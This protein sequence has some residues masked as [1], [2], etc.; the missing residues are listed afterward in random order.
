MEMILKNKLPAFL[1]GILFLSG[2]L[3]AASD[4]EDNSVMQ[5]YLRNVDSVFSVDYI[6]STE[7]DFSCNVM[8]IF[9]ITDQR[10]KLKDIDTASYRLFFKDGELDSTYIIDTAAIKKNV[11]PNSFH[12]SVPWRGNNTFHFY[13]NDTGAGRLAIGF[14]PAKIDGGQLLI[15]LFNINRNDYM[16]EQVLS[17]Y[18]APEAL[19][20][21]SESFLFQRHDQFILLKRF[22]KHA[23]ESGLLSRRYSRQIIEFYDYRIN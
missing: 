22:E 20:R 3:M 1:P 9:R 13:P 2:L 17:H 6:F 21:L 23:V 4:G 8:S 14:E 16:V 7:R 19:E 12:F 11:L 10:G 18:P 5:Y 15:G